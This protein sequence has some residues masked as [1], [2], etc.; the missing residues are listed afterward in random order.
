MGSLREVMLGLSLSLAACH[1][2][3]PQTHIRK[4]TAELRPTD[5]S[6]QLMWRFAANDVVR[7]FGLEDGGFK[8]HYS[9]QG[10]NAV[11]VIDNND[12]GVPDMVE[13]VAQ[14][15]EDVGRLYHGALGYREPLSDETLANNGG[16]GRFDVYLLD[17]A[18]AADGA[19]RVDTCAAQNTQQCQG[20]VVQEND[21]VGYNYPSVR[22]ATRILGS[23]EYF[24]A[25]QAAYDNEQGVVLS[26]ATAVWATEQ[27]DSSTS[28][29]EHFIDGYFAEP[30]RSLDSAPTGPV[31]SFAYGA[32]IWPQFLSE[33]FGAPIVRRLWESVENGHALE[34]QSDPTWLVQLD[35]LLKAEYPS[36]FA[37]AF[38]EFTEWNL[39]LGLTDGGVGYAN[40]R[41]Y[42]LPAR[43]TTGLPVSLSKHR[44]F[45]A[46]ALYFEVPVG[47]RASVRIA[48][49]DD[50][51]TA[52][53]ERQQLTV[54][55][56]A[57]TGDVMTASG[58]EDISTTG[59][60]TL[61]FALIN[62][63]RGPNGTSL[64]K[65][66]NV[67][68]GTPL[69]VQNCI[70]AF[71]P[72]PDAGAPDAGDTHSQSAQPALG[73]PV[74]GCTA[75]PATALWVGLV[76]LLSRRSRGECAAARPAARP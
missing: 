6:S 60:T 34:P 20:Y 61:H 73:P 44:I 48:I 30:G 58:S 19:F 29:L 41:H 71:N 55:A 76:V 8:V 75:S 35:A 22:E 17:F 31:P 74:N 7:T 36:S 10:P 2:P 16:D 68:G 50:P 51:T 65:R 40:A 70:E 66:P 59:A 18:R 12:S 49:L 42:P 33:R 27:F 54:R 15:Y 14:V 4:A 25:V 46:S 23:H 67:C 45:Y 28:D 11:P 9:V 62:T 56:V 21:F 13:T 32:A 64:S 39:R 53:D 57:S 26:E 3:D 47:G 37:Q 63:A 38:T 24:H 43:T 1:Q 52:D 69:E 72:T 5:S